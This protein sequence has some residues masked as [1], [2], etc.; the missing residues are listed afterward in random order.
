[1]KPS[2]INR[3][4]F[5]R[6][7]IVP[8]SEAKVSIM[9]SALNYG[10][11]VFEGIRAYWNEEE[12]QLYIF[13][14]REHFERFLRN[15]R[16]LLIDLPYTVE[17][18]C[19][20]A[21]ELL[22]REGFRRDVYIRPLAY[23]S[24]EVIGVRLHDLESGCAIFA[25]PFGEYIDRPGGARVMVSSWRRLSDNAIPP[26]NKITGAYVNS[27]LAKSEAH[28]NG[29]DDALMLTEDGHLSEGSAANLFLVRDGRLITSPV[30]DEILE[31]ITRATVL[32]FAQDLGIEAL[33][34]RI[35][36]SEIYVAD[37][38]FLCGT[39]VGIVP[40]IEVD[41]RPIGTGTPG[42]ISTEL[43]SLYQAT[44]RGMEPRYRRWCTPVYWARVLAGAED[45]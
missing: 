45:R 26:R 18:L 39:A 43:R 20:L 38:A 25:V 17:Q 14:L 19:A 22:Q 13:R 36:R 29:F 10:T 37:E 7:K 9:T 5:F 15:C 2:E 27:A 28:L 30:S 12:E 8:I 24:S 4:A 32:Q 35:D 33:E 23:K 16:L 6:G 31:G 1:M 40:L 21:V 11:G 34:R 3:Y 42:R 44:V 41:R